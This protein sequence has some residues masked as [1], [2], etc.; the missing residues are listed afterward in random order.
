[1]ETQK[2]RGITDAEF[3]KAVQNKRVVIFSPR[4]RN[5]NLL[6]TPYLELKGSYHYGLAQNDSSLPAFLS[7]LSSELFGDRSQTSQILANNKS[8]LAG[9]VEALVADLGQLKPKAEALILDDFD[10]LQSSEDVSDFFVQL[11]QQLPKG[12]VLVLNGRTISYYPWESMVSSGNAVVLGEE[13]ALDGG[14]FNATSRERPQ[15]EIY[16]FG[17]GRVL[18]NGLP[19]T[20]WDGPLPRNLFYYFIDHP[21]V[22]RDEIFETFW[23]GL[24]TKEATNVFH[25]TKRKISERLG[26]ELTAYSGGF[27]RP[28]EEISIHYDV[29]RFNEHFDKGNVRS[30]PRDISEY[31]EV[32]KLYRSEFLHNFDMIWISERRDQLRDRYAEALINIGRL[33]QET[34]DYEKAVHYYLRA[35]R[36]QPL[37][38]DIHRSLMTIFHQEKQ[39]ALA[40]QQFRTLEDILQR[41]LRIKPSQATITLYNLIVAEMP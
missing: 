32:V 23:P 36:E 41:K 21:M 12:L 22:T 14:I 5:R 37:R 33:H 39:Y 38:E 4:L 11:V 31:Y 30:E 9:W 15:L 20:T 10:K 25:V 6:L 13:Q 3:T 1:M 16:A 40:V 24:S 28:S 2:L 35:L 26:Y 18:M 29:Q 7:N 27:Y 8:K 19:I 34:M 17:T